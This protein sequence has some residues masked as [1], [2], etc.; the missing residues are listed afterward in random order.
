MRADEV[1]VRTAATARRPPGA[2]RSDPAAP[3]GDRDRPP[4]RGGSTRSGSGRSSR[5]ALA[6]GARRGT[7]PRFAASRWG[8]R[9]CRRARTPVWSCSAC[10][11]IPTG[12]VKFT[13]SASGATSVD[14]PR[15]RRASRGSSAAPSRTRRARWSPARARRASAAPPRRSL[16]RAPARRGSPRTRSV[17]PRG[18]L[19]GSGSRADREPA[20]H[21]SHRCAPSAAI[22]S[23]R[24]GS[25]S[26]STTSV[27]TE[28]VPRRSARPRRTKGVRTPV[29]SKRHLH[30]RSPSGHA[31]R[32][33][34]AVTSSAS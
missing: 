8:R 27:E 26:C 25:T 31:A 5:R 23:S 9:R 16:A 30:V 18:A 19:R 22:T 7:R 3:A 17:R 21:S 12:F 34:K 28:L 20:P 33:T 15:R 32:S 14:Q 2:P 13:R 11:T 1:R 4:A 6:R 24:S 29:P 10:I